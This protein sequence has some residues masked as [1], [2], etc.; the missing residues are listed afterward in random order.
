[1]SIIG[2]RLS[3]RSRAKRSEQMVEIVMGATEDD[4]NPYTGRAMQ[5]RTNARNPEK[6]WEEATFESTD[7][8]RVPSAYYVPAN[9][10][11]AVERLRTH[12]I[13]IERLTQPVSGQLEEFQIQSTEAAAQAF[14]NHRERTTTG[15]YMPVDKTIPAGAYRIQMNQ[16]LA[17]L[18]F[19]LLEP[20]SNDSLA[21]WNFLDDALKD[22]RT[23]PIL[24]T[25][26]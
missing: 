16:P 4:I 11:A 5:K 23:Y 13:R 20:R 9:L 24:R 14:E 1:M 7:A 12:G 25:V 6:M 17:R 19:Y 2:Q 18:A 3:L 15:T 21:T 22:A 26:N 10:T 8:E